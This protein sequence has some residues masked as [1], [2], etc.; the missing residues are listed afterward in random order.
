MLTKEETK[1]GATLSFPI[2]ILGSEHHPGPRDGRARAV[3]LGSEVATKP[4]LSGRRDI[5]YFSF[6]ISS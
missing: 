6:P 5:T 4:R 1:D 3:V 2:G